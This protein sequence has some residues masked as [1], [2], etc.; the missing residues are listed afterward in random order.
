MPE[1]AASKEAT[2]RNFNKAQGDNY[3]ESRRD[4]HPVLYH[5]VTD[6]HGSTGGKFGSLLDVGCGP[7]FAARALTPFFE[8]VTGID[9]SEGMITTAQS[10]KSN[11]PKEIRFEISSAEE[12]GANLSPPIPEASVDL[13]VAATCAHWFDM[14][15][16]WARAA[17][18]VKPGGTVAIWGG[19]GI[20]VSETMPNHVAIQ[21]AIDNLEKAVDNYIVDG[22]RIARGLLVDLSLPWTLETPVEEFDEKSFVRKEW[23][24]AIE[25][26]LPA[27]QFYNVERKE[28]F[29]VKILEKILSTASPVIRWR[30]AHPELVGTE[31][32][33]ARVMR[34]EIE[35]A[36]KE[37]GADGD[38][39]IWEG[40][41]Y[42]ALLLVKRRL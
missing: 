27:N 9:V 39:G 16:F 12:L 14:P 37:V 35:A 30:E 2:F 40:G 11:D 31:Q 5:A 17:Q 7:G 3:A 18:V 38:E 42:G 21:R 13:L 10:L 26:A 24:T 4:Y 22:N 6:F 8:N 34:R 29:N 41:V 19:M 20:K 23:G 15:E 36:L 32:D 1:T 33:V 28:S 25:G